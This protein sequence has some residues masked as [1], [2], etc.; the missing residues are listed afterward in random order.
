MAS[1]GAEA[2]ASLCDGGCAAIQT[3]C[4]APPCDTGAPVTPAPSPN[5]NGRRVSVRLNAPNATYLEARIGAVNVSI[6]TEAGCEP[7]EIAGLQILPP[8]DAPPEGGLS[9][10]L[11]IDADI[12]ESLRTELADELALELGELKSN[13]FITYILPGSTIAGVFVRGNDP[14]KAT[15]WSEKLRSFG[16]PKKFGK[17]T[18]KAVE[19][20][21]AHWFNVSAI[22]PAYAADK[23]QTKHGS[24]SIANFSVF[25]FTGLE[26]TRT[27][28]MKLSRPSPPAVASAAEAE[29]IRAELATSLGLDASQIRFVPEP[30]GAR[31]PP[32]L[33]VLRPTGLSGCLGPHPLRA[34]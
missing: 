19:V 4:I 3:S 25:L 32:R 14:Q 16:L 20:D 31:L 30:E 26:V 33:P 27:L 10:I 17:Y 1:D 18:V 21:G 29:K 7:S 11:T 12:D 28:Q 13:I 2:A 23:L 24:D 9:V 34:A 8:H 6:A 15:A 22:L 5:R